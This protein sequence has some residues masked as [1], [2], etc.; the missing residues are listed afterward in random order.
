[1]SFTAYIGGAA[2]YTKPYSSATSTYV[3]LAISERWPRTFVDKTVNVAVGPVPVTFRVQATGELAATLSGKISNVGIEFGGGPSGK[4]SLY[5]SAAVGGEYC[6]W[7]A[8]VGAS[9]GVYASVTL[10]E[11]SAKPNL[12]IWWS[13]TAPYGG[14]QLNYLAN[15]GLTL[16]TLDGEL[17]VFASACLGGCLDW[18]STLIDWPGIT[19]TWYLINATGK[20]CLTGTCT[21]DSFQ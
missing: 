5:A 17:G 8:C 11:A 10:V 13:L 20:Y 15:A 4:A 9:A 2:I 14:I 3:P 18:S 7:G 6:L 1:V 12:A 16:K 19:S 21:G